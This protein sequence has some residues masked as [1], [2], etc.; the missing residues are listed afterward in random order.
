MPSRPNILFLM[1]D[2]HRYDV[3]GYAGNSVVRTP[4]LDV[5]AK[6]A[7]QFTNCYT[8]SPVCI[9]ARQSMMAGK[10][11]RT[12]GCEVFGDDLPPFYRT[13]ARVFSENAYNTIC[14]GKLH[15]NGM[16][17]MQGWLKRIG[18]QMTV[19]PGFMEG[20]D[21][22]EIKRVRVPK[23]ILRWQNK[24]EVLRAGVGSSR[25]LIDDEYTVQGMV[26]VIE[27]IL[28][29]P[30]YDK[31]QPNQP[32]LL[33][34]SFTLP[35]YPYQCSEE[36]FRYYLN[37][38]PIFGKEQQLFGHDYIDTKHIEIGED[39]LERDIV[40]ATAAYYGMVEM[41]DG[42]VG[43]ILAKLEEANQDLDDWIIIFTSDHGEML[44]E[45]GVWAKH[46]F[47]E[48]SAKVPLF[49][50]WPKKFQP[51]VVNQNVN[52]CDLFATLCDLCSIEAPD[53]LDSRSLRPLM[54]GKGEGWDNESVSQYRG[55]FLMIKQDDLKYQYYGED[56]PEVLC[57][58][59]VNPEETKDFSK[60]PAYQKSMAA[61][62]KRGVE[63]GFPCEKEQ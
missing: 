24:K 49:I 53:D 48:G 34:A 35:H 37:R 28:Q 52:L 32:L 15:H 27:E 46:K 62:R 9:P 3:L 43:Q 51:R 36:L 13:F 23:D 2:Q 56:Y 26:N 50:R 20:V 18:S 30:Y 59:K 22:D 60:D 47:Y 39:V 31:A 14:G 12:T 29:S 25:T 6:D 41:A 10:F 1:T 45:H 33:K 4:N 57:D 19:S 42:F 8:P 7:V 61:F 40:R 44:G 16:D 11:P 55:E 38:V 58:L 63:L 54:E 21:H 17:Q 5:L